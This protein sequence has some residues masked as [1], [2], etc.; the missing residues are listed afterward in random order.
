M[1]FEIQCHTRHTCGGRNPELGKNCDILHSGS[2]VFFRIF[3]PRYLAST[4]VCNPINKRLSGDFD[5]Q[6][7][8]QSPDYVA[9]FAAYITLGVAYVPK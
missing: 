1:V 7:I 5:V 8:Q 3:I 6:I 4:S 9:R 2:A